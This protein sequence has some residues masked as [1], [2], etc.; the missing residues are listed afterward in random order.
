MRERRS[1]R[2]S[3]WR[4]RSRCGSAVEPIEAWKRGF[5]PC[6]RHVLDGSRRWATAEPIKHPRQWI[7]VALQRRFHGPIRAIAD[8]A[9]HT[10]KIRLLDAGLAIAD[11]LHGA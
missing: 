3:K 6:Y 9:R 4:L 2:C 5:E 10:E 1:G 11:A 8:P 7:G